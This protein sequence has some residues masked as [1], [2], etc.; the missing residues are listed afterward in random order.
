MSTYAATWLSG[1]VADNHSVHITV[2]AW[3]FMWSMNFWREVQDDE[4]DP[5]TREITSDTEI[6]ERP[7]DDS[8]PP[9]GFTPN[10]T[11][12]YSAESPDNVAS[13]G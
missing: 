10:R 2:S 1:A 7:D 4:P 12:S 9:L 3:G 6:A 11:L 5:E 13:P 8:S